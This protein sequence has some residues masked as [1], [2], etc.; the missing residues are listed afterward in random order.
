MRRAVEITL[1]YTKEELVFLLHTAITTAEN[2][3]IKSMEFDG[4]NFI[5]N[6][7]EGQNTI[8]QKE[9]LSKIN[10]NFL[11]PETKIS[12]LG[13]GALQKSI[14]DSLAN[15]VICS[16]EDLTVELGLKGIHKTNSQLRT[17]LLARKD[18]YI[19]VNPNMWQL[20]QFFKK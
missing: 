14:Q 17:Y 4:E 13:K 3:S 10:F 16:L 12:K 2:V 11:A 9:Q 8:I 18:D 7:I 20:K 5:F 15:G 1:N 6:C 19:E